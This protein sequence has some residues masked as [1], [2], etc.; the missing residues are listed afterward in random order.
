MAEKQKK[1]PS[2]LARLLPKRFRK[3][4]PLVP[5]VRLHGAIGMSSPL[6]PGLSLA[7]CAET[8]ERAFNM[9]GAAAVA[10]S[11]N[12]PGGSPVQSNLIFKRIRAFS[13]EKSIPVYAFC[14]DAAASGGY[15]LACAGDE[16]YADP[17]SIVGSIGVV[18]AGFG[19]TDALQKLG[20]ER[21]V[22]TAGERKVILDPFQPEKPDDV[23]QLLELQAEI[24]GTFKALVAE[25]RG[26]ALKGDEKKLFSGE[27]WAGDQSL[28]LGLI[29]GIGDMRSVLREKLGE[30]VRLKVVATERGWLSKRLGLDSIKPATPLFGG[31]GFSLTEDALSTL[32]VRAL[33][34]RFGL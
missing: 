4:Y 24:H 11:I 9:S 23:K 26:D 12:S 32:E 19:F 2:F 15:M 1:K 28:E 27:F 6:R 29:D 20:V 30:N 7:T 8:L 33:W 31:A 34:A 5:V 17:S 13:E 25:R 3:D 22:Y 18:S 10:L 21:R 16:I 14:E